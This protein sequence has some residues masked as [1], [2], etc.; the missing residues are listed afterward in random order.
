MNWEPKGH[1]VGRRDE[2]DACVACASVG[3]VSSHKHRMDGQPLPQ[4]KT[5]PVVPKANEWGEGVD[6][7]VKE[8]VG[9]NT[10]EQQGEVAHANLVY[11]VVGIGSPP[12]SG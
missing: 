1:D 9:D 8:T 11:V 7:V 2:D 6:A 5:L 4:S 10:S 12:S 3:E